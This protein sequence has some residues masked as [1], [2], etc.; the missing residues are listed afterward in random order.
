M[1][2]L[3]LF[4][5]PR[6]IVHCETQLKAA[7]EFAERTHQLANL[8]AKLLDL[9]LWTRDDA[10]LHLFSD[11]VPHSFYWELH[12]TRIPE[13]TK[14]RIMNGGLIYHGKLE[15]GSQPETFSVN[16]CPNVHNNWSI[17]T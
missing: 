6:M 15:D 2:P 10:Y 16:L 1:T 5:H 9:A 8:N 17:H 12:T 7:S 3:D 4:T 14:T 13:G 11:F